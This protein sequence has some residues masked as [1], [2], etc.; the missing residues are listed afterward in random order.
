MIYYIIRNNQKHGPYNLDTLKAFAE[1]GT[2]LLQ[3]KVEY[4]NVNL[5]L[6][7]VFK[8][9]G[10]KIKIKSDGNLIKQIK[11][12]GFKLLIPKESFTLKNLKNDKKLLVIALVGL[13]PAF[14]IRFTGSSIITF[15]AIAMYFSLIWGFFYHS[16]F[17]TPQV[18]I[19]KSV[20]L[21]F[22]T[23]ALI[24]FSVYVLNLT[25]INPLYSLTESNRSF[26]ERL[27]G[28]IFGVGVF[29]EV[30]KLLPVFFI[31]RHSKEPQIPQT[32]VF[33]G[34]ISGIGFGVFE[35]VFYQLTIN[36]SLDY[37]NSFFMNIARLTC[38][39]FLHSVWSA[40]SSYF[41]SFSFLYPKNRY[42]IW[43]LAVFIPAILHGLYDVFTWSILGLIVC[44]LS[45]ALMIVYLRN[46]KDFQ[47]KMIK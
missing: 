19:K 17:S 25:E 43:L 26:L 6:R 34:L 15:Y 44:Y 24:F 29:E 45:V 41:L 16:V 10:I 13:A 1:E 35:G 7:K 36:K 8:N 28:F 18:D 12:F 21:F 14:L 37:N 42:S 46:A 11:S 20:A 5:T 40:I 2:L 33:Y 31:A 30:L 32:L 27:I 9:A 4:N 38:L 3:D 23:Q 47:N 39:P 22:I